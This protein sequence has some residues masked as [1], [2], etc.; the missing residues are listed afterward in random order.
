MKFRKLEI[1]LVVFVLVL[2]FSCVNVFAANIELEFFSGYT[3]ADGDVVKEIIDDFQ[4]ENPNIK[5]NITTL[6]FTPLFSKFM[7]MV[8]GGNP[9]DILHIHP[10]EI[11]KF[12]NQGLFDD[13]MLTKMSLKKEDFVSSAWNDSFAAYDRKQYGIPIDMGCLAL[14]YNKTLFKEA[15]IENPP[16]TGD[17]L[18]QV[19]QKLTVDK[20]GKHP[21]EPGFDSNNIEIYGLGMPSNHFAFYMWF[22]LINQQNDKFLDDS[23]KKTAFDTQNGI[24]AWKF[25]RD[26]VY[27]YNVVPKGEKSVMDDFRAGKVAMAI[28]GNWW[29]PKMISDP[30]DFEI[31]T[32]PFP[33]VFEKKAIWSSGSVFVFPVNKNADNARKN[34]TVKLA[35][36]IATSKKYIATGHV[37]AYIPSFE[38]AKEEPYRKAIIEMQ[39]YRVVLP[40]IVKST[41][42][43]SAVAPSPIMTAVS[44]VLLTQKDLESVVNQMRKDIEELLD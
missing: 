25:L 6:Q 20:N 13:S 5:V 37:P 32:A 44:A 41:Q 38:A 4:K 36:Y 16:A 19:A 2:A 33:Q 24:K 35:E 28:D 1:I 31:D 17:E 14:Y 23:F 27:T 8:A 15:G 21:N 18:I 3:G 22:A 42:V 30:V 7:T 10:Q 34:A 26:L 39:E 43:Y 29:I 12:A 40:D 11:S 9:P